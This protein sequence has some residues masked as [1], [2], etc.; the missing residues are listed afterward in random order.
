MWTGKQEKSKYFDL[1]DGSKFVKIDANFRDQM[2]C[3]RR[4]LAQDSLTWLVFDP[5]V[6]TWGTLRFLCQ[7]FKI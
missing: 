6:G 4:N 5:P 1:Y 2:I 3:D 7:Q